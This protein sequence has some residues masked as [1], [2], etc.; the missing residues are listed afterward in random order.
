MNSD[1]LIRRETCRDYRETE[2]LVRE[3]FWNVYHPG[4]TEH[5]ILHCFRPRSEF[6]PELDLVMEKDGRIIGQ[7]MYV[8]SAI[9]CADGTQLPVMTFGPLSIH[10]DYSRK[11]LGKRL[12]NESMKRAAA[13]GG[14]A[15]LITGSIRFYEKSGFVPAKTRGIRYQPDPDAEYL[16]VR[17]L[18]EG[19]LQHVRGTFSDPEGYGAAEKNP[20][21]FAR[22][23]AS[24]PEKIKRR[25]P[26]QL[27]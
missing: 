9:C 8:H 1:Y 19:Y 11:G 26:G 17:E 16:L 6:I 20:A 7:I 2:E 22:F 13:L 15:L 21:A 18:K 14:G 25:L 10:P 27:A 12:L 5:Y 3:A 23:D 4:C 24:F